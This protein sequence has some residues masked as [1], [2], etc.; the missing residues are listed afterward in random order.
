MANAHEPVDTGAAPGADARDDSTRHGGKGRPRGVPIDDAVELLEAVGR[1]L[2][3]AADENADLRILSTDGF[4]FLEQFPDRY[5]Q[6]LVHSIVALANRP[7]RVQFVYWQPRYD[8]AVTRFIE[9]LAADAKE[10]G[11]FESADFRLGVITSARAHDRAVP[12]IA[13]LPGATAPASMIF[14]APSD[15]RADA[16]RRTTWW[17]KGDTRANQAFIQ[18]HAQVFDE[19]VVPRSIDFLQPASDDRWSHAVRHEMSQMLERIRPTRAASRG[20][21][22]AGSI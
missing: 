11:L 19:D 3:E 17:I 16:P 1:L 5:C 12:I 15:P 20:S 2:S 21:S 13:A 8:T 7:G 14:E 22:T 18:G 9:T 4:R 6:T 10:R